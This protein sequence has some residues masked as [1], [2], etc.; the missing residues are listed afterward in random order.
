MCMDASLTLLVFVW[1]A[2]VKPP[3]PLFVHFSHFSSF[4]PRFSFV[5]SELEKICSVLPSQYSDTCNNVIQEFG[6]M[7]LSWVSGKV[8]DVCTDVLHCSSAA[9]AVAEEDG[10]L[11]EACELLAGYGIKYLESLN[12]TGYAESFLEQNLCTKLGSDEAV[13]DAA[14]ESGLPLIIN[15]IESY[16]FDASELCKL[17]DLCTSN[18]NGFLC[19]ACQTAT[20][21]ISKAIVNPTVEQYVE[22]ELE[23]IC[24]LLPSADQATC[25]GVVDGFGPTLL[26]WVSGKL[27][28]LCTFAKLC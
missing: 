3:S 6:P 15:K 27:G 5:D 10:L 1:H 22:T 25:K 9:V 20:A 23:Q 16:L 17:A 12:L 2:F 18:A 26:D 7:L 11:C 13:C 14:V 21:A 19:S 4:P 28:D 8:S 24:S